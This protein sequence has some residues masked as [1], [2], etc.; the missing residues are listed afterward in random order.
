MTSDQPPQ[1]RRFSHTYLA[2][3]EPTQDSARM[4]RRLGAVLHTFLDIDN[5]LGPIISAEL[6]VDVPSSTYAYDYSGFL[7]KCELRDFLDFVTVVY[8]FLLKKQSTGTKQRNGQERWVSE[9]QR[10]FT[11][12]NVHYRVDPHG[13]VHFHFD[14]EFA[15]NRAAAIAVLQGARYVNALDSF[16][17]GLAA[18][19]RV[20]PDGKDAIRKTFA[21]IEGLFRQMFPDSQRL[22]AN[23]CDKLM[24]ILQSTFANDAAA[25]GASTKMVESFKDWINAAHNYRHEPG[26]PDVAQPPLRLAVYLCSSGATHLRWL[27]EIDTQR[28]P[29]G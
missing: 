18:L 29:Q 2:K 17:A 11:E 19:S 5:E 20:P 13:G 26:I 28:Q 12:E 10:V 27:A 8:R 23:Q 3:G 15:R 22:A 9:V 24:P 7:Q 4:R 14:E 6:G 25:L 21:A 1:G 16:E